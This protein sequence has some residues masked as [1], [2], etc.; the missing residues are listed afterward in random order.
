VSGQRYSPEQIEAIRAGV[1]R[2]IGSPTIAR[3]LGVSVTGVLHVV[4]RLGLARPRRPSVAERFWAQVQRAGPDQCWI[5]MGRRASS[6][7]DYGAF[8]IR[9]R[10]GKRFRPHHAH[11]VAWEL[12]YGPVPD[13]LFVCH[14]CDNPPCCNPAH[15]FLGSAADNNH[16]KCA[17]GRQVFGERHGQA[18]L[19]ASAVAEMRRRFASGESLCA[20]ARAF[21]VHCSTAGSAIH[22]LTWRHVSE[23]AAPL[24]FA[25]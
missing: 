21:G 23:P 19:T 2:G 15:L 1:V 25:A 20:L 22:G 24:H 9:S 11:R 6:R 7:G 4:R 17:K 14:R 8:D 5:W 12:T 13:G 18:K 3:E 16:D 10:T